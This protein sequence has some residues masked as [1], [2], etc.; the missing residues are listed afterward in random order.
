MHSPA[1]LIFFSQVRFSGD[2][3]L[4]S[5]H[6]SRHSN[7]PNTQIRRR[8]VEKLLGLQSPPRKVAASVT[9]VT[10]DAAVQDS[11]CVSESD[12]ESNIIGVNHTSMDQDKHSSQS[13][14]PSLEIR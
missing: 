10:D 4:T 3:K 12:V 13:D 5:S 14:V 6:R 2:T 1:H 9:K 7:D 11:D 8:H